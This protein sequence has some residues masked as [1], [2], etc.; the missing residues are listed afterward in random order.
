MVSTKLCPMIHHSLNNMETL[1][2]SRRTFKF[3]AYTVSHC[4]LL[5]RSM[6]KFPDQDH[7]SEDNSYNID[8]EFWAV[9]YINIPA[10]LSSISIRQISDNRLPQ[11][12]NR[13]FLIHNEKI[14]EIQSGEEKYYII[15]GGLLIGTN[16]WEKEDR[17]FNYD[18]NLEHDEVVISV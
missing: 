16:R 1:F 15:A 4:S 12:I 18:L 6:M 11:Y 3:L 8:I 10:L 14:F 13:R 2:N 7:Y 17:I 5:L 9:T